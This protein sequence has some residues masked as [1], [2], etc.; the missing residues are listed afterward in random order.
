M[1]PVGGLTPREDKLLT[2][3]H[4]PSKQWR[5]DSMLGMPESKLPTL[6]LRELPKMDFCFCV[7]GSL[8][9]HLDTAGCSFGL[10]C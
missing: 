1:L 4:T 2:K 7:T 9:S 6:H 8:L 5:W 3:V 10:N